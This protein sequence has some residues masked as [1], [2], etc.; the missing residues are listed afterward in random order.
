[1]LAVGGFTRIPNIL[2]AKLVAVPLNGTEARVILLLC[3][4][5]FGWA[6]KE[7]DTP[8][9]ALSLQNCVD[10]LKVSK[11]SAQDALERLTDS[12][13]VTRTELGVGRGY[14][15]KLNVNFDQWNYGKAVQYRKSGTVTENQHGDVPEKR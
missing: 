4:L 1:M 8:S 6:N 5:T 9:I 3:R 2:I 15:Y 14:D 11:S 13:I 12:K 7:N 10:T